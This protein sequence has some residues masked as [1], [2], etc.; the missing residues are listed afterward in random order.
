MNKIEKFK[1]YRYNQSWEF[2]FDLSAAILPLTTL[3]G[4]I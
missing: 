3:F 1:Y 2:L 4:M